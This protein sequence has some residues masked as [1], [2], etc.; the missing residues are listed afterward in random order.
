VLTQAAGFVRARLD[1]F[2]HG[3]AWTAEVHKANPAVVQPPP[4][5]AGGT[6]RPC[7]L[8]SV[9]EEIILHRVIA[10][11]WELRKFNA[12][13]EEEGFD[14]LSGHVLRARLAR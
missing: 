14:G 1:G 9:P 8:C 4:E 13:V 3:S 2:Q 5:G 12:R 6:S 10:A 11:E 7:H